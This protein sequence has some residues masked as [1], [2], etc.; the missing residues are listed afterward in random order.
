MLRSQVG[1][2]IEKLLNIIA[3]IIVSVSATE[4]Y[5]AILVQ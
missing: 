5:E 1:G 2:K 3:Y 4:S